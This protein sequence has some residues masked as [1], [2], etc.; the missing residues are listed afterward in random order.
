MFIEFW[1]HLGGIVGAV[2]ATKSP[3]KTAQ[4]PP[5]MPPEGRLG[6]VLEPGAA[7]DAP[8]RRPTHLQD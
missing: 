2:L 8:K 7:Q 4:E 3:P 5:K 1:I 6:G